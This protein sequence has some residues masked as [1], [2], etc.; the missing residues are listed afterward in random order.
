M[1]ACYGQGL[2]AQGGR[3]WNLARDRYLEAYAGFAALG[4]PVPQGLALAGLARCDEA[5]GE[6]TAA[7]E[8]YDEV[9]KLSRRI[10]EPGLT[11]T[12]LEGLCR[13]AADSGDRALAST[14]LAEATQLRTT[15][16]RPSPPHERRDLA[17][18]IVDLAP[19]VVP[20]V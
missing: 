18:T 15:S 9:L 13:L 8:R 3:D 4:T 17:A 19:N 1:L 12:A 14:L 6:A 5:A 11:S 16:S 2:L 20:S 7:R 10:G